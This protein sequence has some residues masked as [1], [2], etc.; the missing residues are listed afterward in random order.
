MLW[1]TSCSHS[2]Y[3]LEVICT[4]LISQA[5]FRRKGAASRSRRTGGYASGIT[6][7]YQFAADAARRPGPLARQK[8]VSL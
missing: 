6:F 5:D 8:A 7:G 3:V 2:L 4:G 1:L